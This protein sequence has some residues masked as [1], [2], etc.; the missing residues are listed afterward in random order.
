MENRYRF[1]RYFAY[2]L[3][4][5]ILYMLQQTPGLLPPLLGAR[6][7]LIIPA[8]LAIAMF[9]P[10][11][12]AMAFGIF[13][14]LL[15]DFG[16]G[17]ALGFHGIMLG[18][19]GYLISALCANLLRANLLTSF[20]INIIALTL[21][22]LLQWVFYYVL[23]EYEEPMYALVYHYLPRIAYSLILTPITFYF[24]RAFAM[25]IQPAE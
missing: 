19:S 24:N 20:L 2:A 23:Y 15:I 3:E 7:I 13:G 25:L 14:G 9:E 1:I 6:P 8:V 5:L 10:E 22:V 17:D 18:V 12:P 4:L 16:I 11:V 21:V